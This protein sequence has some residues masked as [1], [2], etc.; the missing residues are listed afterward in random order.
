MSAEINGDSPE[1]VKQAVDAWL[2]EHWDN[3]KKCEKGK[4]SYDVSSWRVMVR[5]SG[6]GAPTWSKDWYGLGLGTSQARIIE[7]AF[8]ERG[9]PGYAL[10][11]YHLGA[12][13]LNRLGNYELKKELLGEI[14]AGPA[15]C[16]LY[17]EPNAGSDLAG[18][19]LRAEKDGDEY[20]VNGQKVWT[21]NA[22]EAEY[23]VLLA[24]TDWNVPKHQGISFFL[25]PMKQAGVDIRPINQITGESEFNEIF[26]TNARMP[27]R[28]LIGEL[29]GGWAVLQTAL[30]YER[31]IMGE[32]AA[33]GRKRKIQTAR[34]HLV[35]YADKHGVLTEPHMRQKLAHAIGRRKLND[36][37]L[38][39]AKREIMENGSSSLMSL[40]KLAMSHIQHGEAQLMGEMLGSKSLLDGDAYPDSEM[41]NF[42]SAKAYMN[43]I[44]GGT[45]QIQRNI[46]AERILGLPR[47]AE[48]DRNIPFK[49]VKSG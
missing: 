46:I 25:F 40:G 39:R 28:Y 29:N 2:D 42:N 1:A 32:G 37:N 10:D 11:R 13:T 8:K 20:I 24:R 36:L 15:V 3:E 4:S 5:D 23:G 34:P 6:F 48:V 43:S 45:D 17:S 12:A 31:L 7:K 22:T 44:G 41:M 26:F 35:E 38:K 9:A 21:S 49:D 30:A 27:E 33:Q 18:I 14:L 19:R 16:L 47:E